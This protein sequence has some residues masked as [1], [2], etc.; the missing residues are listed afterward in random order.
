MIAQALTRRLHTRIERGIEC[1]GSLQYP[2]KSEVNSTSHSQ[3]C[4]R[5]PLIGY[6]NL[7]KEQRLSSLYPSQFLL[8]VFFKF[9]RVINRRLILPLVLVV[10]SIEFF[11]LR[12]Q[13]IAE[14]Q[15]G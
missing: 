9:Q 10:C 3:G 11:I 12:L 2:L 8:H 1:F 13:I 6:I 14:F 15:H 4:F 7:R 5:F